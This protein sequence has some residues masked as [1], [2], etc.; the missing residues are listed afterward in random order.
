MLNIRI[1]LLCIC[2]PMLM[3][4][5]SNNIT[6]MDR[7]KDCNIEPVISINDIDRFKSDCLARSSCKYVPAESCYCPPGVQCICGGGAPPDCVSVG[8]RR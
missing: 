7:A 5:M 6:E 4:C 2:I 1:I 3:S 8:A